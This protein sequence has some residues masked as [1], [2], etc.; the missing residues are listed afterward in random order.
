MHTIRGFFKIKE[1]KTKVRTEVVAGI[2]TF[3]TMSYIIFLQPSILSGP[4][5][6]P[7]SGIKYQ[8]TG[9]P[10]D[11]V[12]IGVCVAAAFGSILMGL[13][14]NYPVALAPGM[15]ENFFFVTVIGAC[16]SLGVASPETAWQTALGVVFI[17]GAIFLI[18]SF[19]NVREMMMNSI[20]PS[21]K[22]A[23]ACGI[24][25]FIALIGFQKG[26]VIHS[27]G[28]IY[29][30]N[31]ASFDSKTSLIF[32]SGL[33]V[34]AV[35]HVLKVKGSVL[36]GILAAAGIALLCKK[37]QYHGFV[38]MPQSIGPV[39]AKMDLTNVFI[40]I[41]KLLP[42]I[43]IFTFMDVFD[44]L[45]TLVGVTTQSGLMKDN[46]LPNAKRAF[47]ADSIGTIFGVFCG[48]STVTSYVESSTG[49]EYG[50][51]TGLT[52]VTTGLCF[53]MA[54]LFTPFIKMIGQYSDT[55]NINPIIAP[56][57]VIVGAIMM[58]S[59]KHIDWDDFSEAIPAFLILAGIPFTYSIADGLTLGFIA[60]PIVK[61][62]GGKGKQIGWL[63]YLIGF[64][65]LLYIVFVKTKLLE[66]LLKNG[67]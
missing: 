40:N 6:D 21:M 1:R 61:L 66:E 32:F 58:Q 35:L 49:V 30:L 27:T 57:L 20:S 17:S 36:W 53:L 52:A 14:A 67:V 43:I 42:F 28:G 55:T 16:I 26:G 47:A 65:L 18:L 46:K 44:T 45:G 63:T 54:L 64:I 11:A 41:V 51:R 48:Q 22:H 2:T 29:T 62:F 15:G 13:W 59:V 23:M 38:K 5:V 4:F 10:Y 9:M 60:Y 31:A 37:I 19:L 7:S 8:S 39:F 3:L 56:A 50:G 24:G 25:L 33:I 12:L 34:I